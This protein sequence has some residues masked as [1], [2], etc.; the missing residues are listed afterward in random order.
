MLVSSGPQNS[1]TFGLLAASPTPFLALRKRLALLSLPGLTT[2]ASLKGKRAAR[3]SS[4]REPSSLVRPQILGLPNFS[5]ERSRW[6][7]LDGMWIWE[8]RAA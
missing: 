1:P 4:P 3:S 6:E 5:L 8:P 2:L 7:K